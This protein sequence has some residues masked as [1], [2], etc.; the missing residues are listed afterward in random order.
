MLTVGVGGVGRM[1]VQ[2]LL[3]FYT[4]VFFFQVKVQLIYDVVCFTCVT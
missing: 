4:L 3:Y 2:G 1:K